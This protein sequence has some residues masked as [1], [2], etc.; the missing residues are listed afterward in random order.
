MKFYEVFLRLINHGKDIGRTCINI[1]S[2]SPFDASLK[3][4]SIIDELYQNDIYSTTI[5]VDEISR[6]EYRFQLAA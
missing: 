3:A 6:E 1:K 4:E 5:S 2:T